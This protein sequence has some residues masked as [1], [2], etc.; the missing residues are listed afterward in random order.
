MGTY[1]RTISSPPWDCFC[2][3]RRGT[4]IGEQQEGGSV[5]HKKEETNMSVTLNPSAVNP[6]I[7]AAAQD[8][9]MHRI[10]CGTKLSGDDA[11]IVIRRVLWEGTA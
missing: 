3:S 1:A 4:L 5:A 11:I 7:C 10:G 8:E 2:F 6:R 9:S